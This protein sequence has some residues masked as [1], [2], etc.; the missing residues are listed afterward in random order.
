M[1]EHCMKSP[2]ISEP[3]VPWRS[4]LRRQNKNGAHETDLVGQGPPAAREPE[5]ALNPEKKLRGSC[6]TPSFPG[7]GFRD[8]ELYFLPSP[9]T[10]LGS[11]VKY[12]YIIITL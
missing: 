11:A 2:K 5:A 12:I 6:R 3:H 7:Q 8:T 1:W 9:V 4:G 10:L